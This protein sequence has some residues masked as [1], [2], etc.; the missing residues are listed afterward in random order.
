MK[1]FPKI[2]AILLIIFQLTSLSMAHAQT[3]AKPDPNDTVSKVVTDK[4]NEIADRTIFNNFAAL[5]GP[6][7]GMYAL[8]IDLVNFFYDGEWNFRDSLLEISVLFKN[9]AWR[10]LSW[11]INDQREIYTKE[12]TKLKKQ[13]CVLGFARPEQSVRDQNAVKATDDQI[14]RIDRRISQIEAKRNYFGLQRRNILTDR[15]KFEDPLQYSNTR[16]TIPPLE[17]DKIFY[18]IFNSEN[19]KVTGE[20]I[21]RDTKQFWRTAGEDMSVFAD[22]FPDICFGIANMGHELG[23][24][25]ALTFR[26]DGSNYRDDQGREYKNYRDFVTKN[27]DPIIKSYSDTYCK[28]AEPQKFSTKKP[29]SPAELQFKEFQKGLTLIRKKITVALRELEKQL[30]VLDEKRAKAPLTPDEQRQLSELERQTGTYQG[31][32]DY[33]GLVL[34]KVGSGSKS[35]QALAERLNSFVEAIVG[36]ERDRDGKVSSR[37]AL[38]ERFEK[39]KEKQLKDICSRIEAMYRAS[40]RDTGQLPIIGEANGYVYCRAKTECEDVGLGNIF[41]GSAGLKKLAQCSGFLFDEHSL[42]PN[43]TTKDIIKN[44]GEDIGY[45]LEQSSYNDLLKVQKLHYSSLRSQYQSLYKTQSGVNGTLE[46]MLA[47]VSKNL[48]NQAKPDVFSP[49]GEGK[50]QYS[51]LRKIYEEFWIFMSEQQGSCPAPKDPEK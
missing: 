38:S 21:V 24:Y 25:F 26:F 36:I 47:D 2:S 42:G 1:I 33:Y 41:G 39:R 6:S 4:A 19:F 50:T 40:G 48:Y 46:N 16:Y 31:M 28:K 18:E 10:E 34:S 37:L 43:Q 20:E 29:D 35:L 49:K 51:V 32:I 17:T 5:A 14:A 7:C 45:L 27:R 11:A 30:K 22:A 44:V 9:E 8:G 12:L 13:Q 23:L 3:G 15:P